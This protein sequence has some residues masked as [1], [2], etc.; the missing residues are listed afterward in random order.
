MKKKTALITGVSGYLGSHLAKSLKLA[1]WNVVGLDVKHTHNQYLDIFHSCDVR[2][3]EGLHY[4][5]DRIDVDTVFH[6]AGKIEVGESV[7]FPQSFFDHNVNGTNTLL[8][9]M[10]FFGVKNIVYS[11]TASVYKSKDAALH[12]CDELEPMNNPYAASKYAAE[13]AIRHSGLNHI[14]FRYF[15]LAGA[16]ADLEMGEAHIPETHLIPKLIQCQ[17]IFKIFGNDYDTPDGTCIR[18]FVHVSDVADA[19]VTAANHLID[20]GENGIFNLGTGVGYSVLEII[21]LTNKIIGENITFSYE[22]RRPGD[23]ALLIA[24]IKYAKQVL[25]YEPQHDIISILSTANAWHN[26]ND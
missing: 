16:D 13:L 22:K 15:N 11:S 26:K 1:G 18:D 17:N 20:G 24:D 10:N 19:H 3:S 8:G 4:F 12:E 14:I 9:V 5:F 6:L 2:D 25:Q 23:P 7:K 21:N